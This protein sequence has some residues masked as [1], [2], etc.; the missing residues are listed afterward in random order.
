MSR[1]PTWQVM[2]RSSEIGSHEELCTH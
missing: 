2:L 1:D